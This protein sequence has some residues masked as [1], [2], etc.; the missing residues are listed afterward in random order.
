MTRLSPDGYLGHLRTE[1]T[2]LRTALATCDPGATVPTC[3]DW[4]ALDLLGHHA[5]VLYFWAAIIEGR[6][7]GPEH[8]DEPEKPSDHAGLLTFHAE[9]QQRLMDALEAADPAEEA[10]SWAA[11]QTVGFTL[12]RQAHEALIHR[13]DAELTAGEPTALDPALAADGVDEA[14]DVMFGGKPPWGEFT[15]HDELVRVACTDTGDV[16]WVRLGHFRGIS[17]EGETHD[18]PDLQ[19]VA[20]PGREPDAEVRGTAATLDAWLWRRTDDSAVTVSGD[21]DVLGRFRTCVDQPIT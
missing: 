13:L 5:R 11:E 20:D 15:P 10:W 19:V 3:P 6:P 1:S 18:T 21:L 9:Q 7:A 14:L 12:R 17:P 2:R 16:S 4:T 8:L